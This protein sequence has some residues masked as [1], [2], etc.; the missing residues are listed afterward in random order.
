LRGVRRAAR[1]AR[2]SDLLRSRTRLPLLI[3]VAFAAF[4]PVSYA[5]TASI[6]WAKP[7]RI[8]R[9]ANGG[10][11]AIDCQS[12]TLCIA[13]DQ[14]GYILVS[15]KPTAKKKAWSRTQKVD[16]ARGAGLTGISCPSASLCVAVDSAG[17]VITSTKP[18]G[19]KSAWSKPVRVD[20]TNAAGGGYAGLVAVDC[21]TTSLCVA[22]D[23]GD[24]ANIVTSTNPTG[25]ASAWKV[26]KIGGLLT[27]VTCSSTSFCV[28]AGTEHYVSTNPTGGAS[29]W[30]ATGAQAGGGV[31]SDVA[32]PTAKTCVAVG[33]GDSSTGLATASANPRASTDWLEV[34]LQPTPAYPGEGVLDGVSC[35]SGVFC[36]AVDS[37]DNA[38]SSNR[39]AHGA[40]G[41][42]DKIGGPSSSTATSSTISCAPTLCV[43]VDSNGYAIAGTKRG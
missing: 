14:S 9:A 2:T 6:R 35:L 42:A 39:P 10:L 36:V 7:R 28:A 38:Y 19:G 23:G 41:A 24:P 18:T 3:A 1:S 37:A 43:V 30:K 20:S 16:G 26:T 27:S 4:A 33:Y 31:F 25:G 17:N 5:A 13:G 22:A 29:A 15:T 32:C 8:E 21:P 11:T 12:P 40:W 34:A